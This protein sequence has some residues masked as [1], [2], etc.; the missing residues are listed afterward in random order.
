MCV[1]FI[2][3]TTFQNI[4]N[5]SEGNVF[6][7]LAVQ[8]SSLSAKFDT[9][10]TYTLLDCK[11]DA[12]DAEEGKHVVEETVEATEKEDGAHT[13]S[14]M[15]N[16]AKAEETGRERRTAWH[17]VLRRGVEMFRSAALAVVG[18]VRGVIGRI[19][20]S[21]FRCVETVVKTCPVRQMRQ[22]VSFLF[23]FETR[24]FLLYIT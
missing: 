4:D 9:G 24:V 20:A 22:M 8:G 1:C 7:D 14:G 3:A 2:F 6:I 12:G 18:G 15:G 10:N 19:A 11:E 13:G 16:G 21:P 17:G 23:A 5:K